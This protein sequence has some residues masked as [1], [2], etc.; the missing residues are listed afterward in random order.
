MILVTGGT[1]LVGSHLLYH[2]LKR[3]EK[4]RATKRPTSNVGDVK[5]AFSFYGDA[6]IDLLQQVEWVDADLTNPAAVDA[7]FTDVDRV[8][9]CAAQVSFRPQD[10]RM[11][12]TINPKITA[13]LVN[14]ALAHRIV[15][16]AHVSSVA[17][18]GR[19]K[20][21]DELITEDMEW[22]NDTHVSNYAVSK[23]LSELEVWRGIEE[24]LCAGMIN[25]TLIMGP[26]NWNHSSNVFFKSL[27]KPFKFYTTGTNG[28]VDVR[29]V[30]AALL[31]ISDKKV[32][33]ER[34]IISG[35]NL[36]YRTVF[37]ALAQR[38]GNPQPAL[39]ANPFIIDVIW[40]IEWLRS[41]LT[42]SNPIMTKEL[43]VTTQSK[44][45]YSNQKAREQLGMKF[46][47]IEESFDEFVPF[48]KEK[49]LS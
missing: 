34:Y 42:G 3:G 11:M 24:G 47:K 40:R 20:E 15:H 17:S 1:G 8:F 23:Y 38:F 2:L 16:F 43:A 36:A 18:I 6:G 10:A 41:R 48:Y 7:L 29:D 27:S 49:Y 9:H 45:Q 25:P 30:V 37:N 26:G 44:W 31:A 4:V 33:G 32:N 39:R 14:A 13:N 19:K 5:L 12:R 35:E 28:F 21:Q 22:K 46:R